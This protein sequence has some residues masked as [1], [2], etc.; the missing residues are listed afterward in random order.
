MLGLDILFYTMI[1][2]TVERLCMKTVN[3]KLLSL[4]P[5]KILQR[6]FSVICPVKRPKIIHLCNFLYYC[7]KQIYVIMS[8]ICGFFWKH[9]GIALQHC[10][11]LT[12]KM[13]Y[14]YQYKNL[15]ASV[16]I[17][18]QLSIFGFHYSYISLSMSFG[19]KVL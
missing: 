1:V 9:F 16:T 18:V 13:V 2:L 3:Q 5:R 8:Y 12:L 4:Q 14:S 7:P 17:R 15:S 11:P 10:K 6:T 19:I